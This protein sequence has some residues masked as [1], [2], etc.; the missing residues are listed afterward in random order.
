MGGIT[1]DLRTGLAF[2]TRLP[3]RAPDD[4][5]LSR[6]AWT[7]PIAGLA[8]GLIGGLVLYLALGFGVPPFSAATLAVAATALT[9]G[10]LH[11][12]GLA[13]TAD[14]FGGGREP[15]R[16]REIL[17]DSRIGTYGVIALIISFLLRIGALAS[18]AAVGVGPAVFALVAAHVGGRA[19]LP[20]MMRVV[21][22]ARED[23]LSAT[24][25]R[26]SAGVTA[27]A[28]AIGLVVAVACLGLGATLT[29]TALGTVCLIVLARMAI[30]KIGGQT[31]D[32]LGAA[33]Q[34]TE[35]LILLTAAALLSG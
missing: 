16:V 19:A 4:T 12:D 22:R 1:T 10:C 13:D 35:I 29:A 30:R 8:V 31:G 17:R 21:P 27:G 5:P 32:V 25:G 11:E 3:M 18:L 24:A 20:V 34:V 28:L 2:C 15:E 33:E 9:T 23:G 7:L 26:P 14:G 6:A